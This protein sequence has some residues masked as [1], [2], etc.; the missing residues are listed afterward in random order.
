MRRTRL[1]AEHSQAE[2]VGKLRS[3]GTLNS[4]YTI[5]GPG[6]NLKKVSVWDD[7]Y[8]GMLYND[9][10]Q[11]I[12]NIQY[13]FKGKK[14][15]MSM[16]EYGPREI[17]C[18]IKDIDGTEHKLNAKQPEW[19]NEQKQWVLRGYGDRE[20]L[21]NSVKNFILE[22][23]GEGI[24]FRMCK[25]GKDAFTMDYTWPLC[26]MQGFALALSAFDFHA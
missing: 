20:G 9:A 11:Q 18:T 8:D 13:S 10:R 2:F 5:H 6:L 14:K 24:V 4:G 15:L 7:D 25:C 16:N 26:P 3:N 23:E 12:G 1:H 22:V 21:V 17:E 19:D